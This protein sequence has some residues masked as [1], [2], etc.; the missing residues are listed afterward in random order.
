MHLPQTRPSR[1]GR[2]EMG[3]TAIATVAAEGAR[4]IVVTAVTVEIAE[5]ARSEA[6]EV[7]D[8]AAIATTEAR[9]RRVTAEVVAG[10]VSAVRFPRIVRN[11]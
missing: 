8:S 11:T 5:I 6:I 7:A 10:S 1:A 4:R 3:A 9:D 2:N